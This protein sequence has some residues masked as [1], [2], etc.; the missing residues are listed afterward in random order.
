M[1]EGSTADVPGAE[2]DADARALSSALR[3]RILRLCLDEALTNNDIAA[4]LGMNPATTYHHVRML[5]ERGFLAAETERR[6]RRGA[7]EVPYRATGKSWDAPLGPGQSRVL[8]Q[9][10]LDEF[11]QAD[12]DD[13]AIIRLGV[14]LSPERRDELIS[15]IAELFTEAKAV[16]PDPDGEPWSLFFVAHEDVGRR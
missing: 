8:V 9:A 15:R 5:A 3:M 16:G 1:T 4:K 13:A 7:R 12:P 2:A 10:F 11:A 14:R 6:G